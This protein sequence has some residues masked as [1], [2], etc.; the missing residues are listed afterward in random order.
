M[1][2]NPDFESLVIIAQFASVN[3]YS[4]SHH[5]LRGMESDKTGAKSWHIQSAQMSMS[6]LAPG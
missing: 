2:E 6:P 1:T 3:I 5:T 4:Y